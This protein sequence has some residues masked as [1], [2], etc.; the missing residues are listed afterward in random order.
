MSALARSQIDVHSRAS[1]REAA[2]LECWC[3][4]GFVAA[5][6]F[7]KSSTALLVSA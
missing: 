1:I 2:I 5:S 3:H 7:L 6:S 4:F